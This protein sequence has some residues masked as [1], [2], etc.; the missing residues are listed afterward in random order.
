[1]CEGEQRSIRGK[2]EKLP[3]HDQ[4][5]VVL[6]NKLKRRRSRIKNVLS[7]EFTSV[8]KLLNDGENSGGRRASSP[9]FRL[10]CFCLTGG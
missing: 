6:R 3:T 9:T 2:F 8:E 10:L 1:V 4:R 7:F 5:D